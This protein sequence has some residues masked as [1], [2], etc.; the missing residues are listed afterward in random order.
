[1]TLSA[2]AQTGD[3]GADDADPQGRIIARI[4]DR[5][6]DDGVDDYRIE[7]GFFPQWA[8]EDK[9]PWAE[10]ITT[11]SSWL[12]RAR[13]L[14]KTVIDRRD[15]DDNRRWLRSSLISVPASAQRS[16]GD[17]GLE[18]GGANGP[19][20]IEGR[21]IAR[22]S[23]DSQGRLRIE[24][25][26]LPE[27][28]FTNT[29][30]TEEAVEQYGDDFLPRARYLTASMIESRRG[31]WLR[32][33]VVDLTTPEQP[34]VIN[35]ISCLPLRPSVNQPV[36]CTATLNPEGGAPTN[37]QWSGGSSDSKEA[38]T[39][40][41]TFDTPGN[42][43]VSLTVSN[44]T[45]GHDTAVFDDVEVLD[46]PVPTCTVW[47]VTSDGL[48]VAQITT[49][50]TIPGSVTT[51]IRADCANPNGDDEALTLTASSADTTI[52]TTWCCRHGMVSIHPVRRGT[53]SVTITATDS[54][55]LSGSFSFSLDV[56]N[57]A[58]NPINPS[59]P[60]LSV[61]VYQGSS[62]GV[63]FA[64]RDGDQFTV[65]ATSSDP[66]VSNVSVEGVRFYTHKVTPSSRG[67][68]LGRASLSI[69][70]AKAG[71][72]TIT[73]I[74]RDPHGAST[75]VSFN[76]ESEVE[77][78]KIL[79]INCSPSTPR[80]SDEVVCMANT[81]IVGPQDAH[82]YSWS[83]GVSSDIKP[84]T[85]YNTRFSS[86]GAKTV[87]LSISNAGGSDTK[88]ITVVVTGEGGPVIDSI[89][90]TPSSPRVNQSVTCTASLSGGTPDSYS[91]SD[92]DGGS[93]SDPRETT[94]RTSFRSSGTKTVRL[95]ARNSADSDSRSTTV[96]VNTPPEPVGSIADIT[97][98]VGD[99][100]TVDV[101]GNFRDADED[102]LTYEVDSDNS[103]VRVS[104]SSS[105]VTVEGRR[106]G[107]ATITVTANDGNGGSATQW[108]DVTVEGEGEPVIDSISCTP[109]SPRVDQSVTCTASL[110]GGTPTSYL[111]SGGSSSDT[112][113]TTTY[114]TSFSSSGD[115]TVR[116]TVRNS[117]GSDTGSATVS[118]PPQ[119]NI[120][121]V[122]RHARSGT[123]LSAITLYQ[124][125][126][127]SVTSNRVP[128]TVTCSDPAGDDNDL[129]LSSTSGD[130]EIGWVRGLGSSYTT[131]RPGQSNGATTVTITATAPDG[132]TGSA[133]VS[134]TSRPVTGVVS[135][136]CSPSS[137]EVDE[138]VTCTAD[139]DGS[140]TPDSYSWSGGAS[141][142]SSATYQT[143]FSSAGDHTVRLTVRNDYGNEGSTSSGG[144][145]T[146]T[147]VR[148]VGEPVINS[149]SCT[150]SSPTVSQPV[151]CTANLSGDTPT[152]YSWSGGV[153]SDPDPTT[154]YNTTFSA[155][156]NQTV[157]LTVS[158][159]AGSDDESVTLSVKSRRPNCGS[160][161]GPEI[162]EGG[163][164]TISY[165][166][167][168]PDGDT[169][170]ITATSSDTD[171]ARVALSSS[172]YTSDMT[173][174]ITGV[175][176]G[177]ATIALVASDGTWEIVN[178]ADVVVVE[179]PP[180]PVINSISCSPSSPRVNQS[181]TCT[182]SLSGG[183]PTTYS[184]SGGS[185]SGS[186]SSS[187]STSF[188]SSGTKV[189]SL[190][191]SNSA[192]SDSDSTT[193][194]VSSQPPVINSIS[195]SPSSP[196]VDQSVTCT[197]SL[198]G[199][200][201]SSYSWTGGGSDSSGTS[202]AT[203]F[204]SSGSRSIRLTVT[205]SAGSDSNAI[206]V[207]VR[208]PPPPSCDAPSNVNF[209]RRGS[210]Q[211]V[212]VSCTDYSSLAA[213]SDDTRVARVIVRGG[214][215]VVEGQ[216]RGSATITVTVTSDGG[217]T[218]V[219]FDAT[220]GNSPPTC[221]FASSVTMDDD[222]GGKVDGRCTDPDGDSTTVRARSNNN[223]V[224]RVSETG[225]GAFWLRTDDPG[226]ATI[227]YTVTDG[228]GGTFRGSVSVTVRDCISRAV[229]SGKC[230]RYRD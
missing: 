86:P 145:T 147:V 24:F 203:S 74:A 160:G 10:A 106:A 81:H 176:A 73:V 124:R 179:A 1:M 40:I 39:Y 14:T 35:S 111:W 114:S 101:R 178:T 153:S 110:S 68:F 139:L 141:S 120:S 212:S 144:Q 119:G 127:N 159:S 154:T 167:S 46:G 199:G 26:F 126:S 48:R 173:V 163:S 11:W 149:I 132:R 211:N 166:C 44:S 19:S 55:G 221:N 196:R 29:S 197:A 98:D 187:Y 47:R 226:S 3:D 227:S 17:A 185:S 61:R 222:D 2:A 53:T 140:P 82:E 152:T 72:V 16:G 59:P 116:L 175:S 50:T 52:A 177:R 125:A 49:G 34:P 75:R 80:V 30:N 183:T 128:I 4:Q 213:R 99:S 201:P 216:A 56:L 180:P 15:A 165:T 123:E 102:R 202:Y 45:T 8:M 5:T 143:S 131:F 191:V 190:S 193:V 20:Q 77:P 62:A 192:G 92:S 142:G 36:T 89:S 105:R 87:F 12:P 172:T 18:G 58:P 138:T 161:H 121:C 104:A 168:D 130:S 97:L 94:Y 93:S 136:S 229:T 79:D 25:G 51:S 181:V 206:S 162:A 6:D 54:D 198:G 88:S 9:D 218:T 204:S 137:P 100:Q 67:A 189:V 13:Y 42:K 186:S 205:N 224:A 103:A 214:Q 32:S 210:S 113:P 21:V 135:V 155:P 122:I 43:T 225:S 230:L 133:S 220:V 146:V 112:N 228:H 158:N 84:T 200:S 156:G 150:P 7:F 215:V 207:T 174:T 219:E 41:T 31:V 157:S 33:S 169:L 64:E 23:P 91:W 117:A 71:E 38:A 65:T 195:C 70:S 148:G 223:D 28:A 107:S 184:W 208:P 83:G 188:S 209:A 85:T 66:T 170:T 134:V 171:V 182:A 217:T 109:S 194:V 90:C 57:S 76:V 96:I 69:T 95:T 27:Y 151:T 63:T 108:L 78:P 22:Y 37:Y 115:K 164:A 60:D 118:V 129:V